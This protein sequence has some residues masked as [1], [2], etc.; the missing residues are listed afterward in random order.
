MPTAALLAVL[1]AG[2]DE[3]M[4]RS[5]GFLKSAS[6]AQ[7]TTVESV[8][9]RLWHRLPWLVFGLVGALLAA[10]VVG[11][12]E[13]VLSDHVL[14]AFFVPGVVYLAD[15][16]G[17]QTEVL[18]IRG[19]SPGVG[20]RQVAGRE[21][22][23]GILLGLVLGAVSL[24]LVGTLWQNWLAAHRHLKHRGLFDEVRDFQL[25]IDG[26]ERRDQTAGVI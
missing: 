11:S 12:F 9:R 18:V 7:L 3:D 19:L 24:F 5:G 15:A 2:H 20:M 1:L 13:E 21:I 10:G 25:W 4:V 8:P 6:P 26:V 16:I 23:T 22:I 14:I 17:T